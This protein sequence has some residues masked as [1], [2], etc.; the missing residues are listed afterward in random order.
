MS[1]QLNDDLPDIVR[2]NL[3]Y[4]DRT[5]LLSPDFSRTAYRLDYSSPL[6]LLSEPYKGTT[7][8]TKRR[9]LEYRFKNGLFPNFLSSGPAMEL[10]IDVGDL[11]MLCLFG[12]PPNI[13]SYLQRIGRAGRATKKALIF[14]VSKRNPID[15]YYYKK[16]TDLIQSKSQPVPLNE[17]NPE[18]VRISLVWALIDFIASN[19][20]V[21]WREERRPTGS[22]V[23]DGEET[24]R[25]EAP[26]VRPDG[27]KSF[28]WVYN[29]KCEELKFGDRLRILD[30]IIKDNQSE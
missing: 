7:E 19:F 21:P 14:S 13:N 1:A 18:V 23:T 4:K 9:E 2:F 6:M 24:V 22:L 10:G 17:H 15:Y 3:G 8:K 25:I 27:I 5:T 29:R 20:W 28:T 16:P 26:T 11:N 12:T 30:K